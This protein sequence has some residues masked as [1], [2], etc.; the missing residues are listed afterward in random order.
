[1]DAYKLLAL[2]KAERDRAIKVARA[3]MRIGIG[4]DTSIEMTVNAQYDRY[5]RY[6]VCHEELAHIR[7]ANAR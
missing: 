1:M 6:Q 7:A 3:M 5:R 4:A 2:P